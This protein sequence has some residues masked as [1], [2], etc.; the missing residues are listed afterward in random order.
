M[1]IDPE[2]V[3]TPLSREAGFLLNYAT[4]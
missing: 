2:E 1:S 4:G 3:E